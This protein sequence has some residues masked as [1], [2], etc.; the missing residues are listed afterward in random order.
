MARDFKKSL[1][2]YMLLGSNAIGPLLDGAGAI[3]LHTWITADTISPLTPGEGL[4]N[5]IFAAF[6]GAAGE[7]TAATLIMDDDQT[8]FFVSSPP[9]EFSYFIKSNNPL[10]LG[11][12]YSIGYVF[13]M[14]DKEIRIYVDGEVVKFTPILFISN[15]SYNHVTPPGSVHDGVG[16]HDT[17]AYATTPWDG[18]IGDLSIYNTDI[19]DDAFHALASGA[20][21]LTL[22]PSPVFYLDMG[23][24]DLRCPIS[25]IEAQVTGTLDERDHPPIIYEPHRAGSPIEYLRGV[26]GPYDVD[27]GNIFETGTSSGD[28]RVSGKSVGLAAAAGALAGE[29]Q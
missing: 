13:N 5:V 22:N 20:D 21:P 17:P 3:S 12:T 29:A 19:G 2:D 18:M 11:Q 9:G 23:R 28:I 7:H 27:S 6:A 15:S 16:T 14:A 1:N 24:F 26:G 25:G 8:L 4:K 10:T